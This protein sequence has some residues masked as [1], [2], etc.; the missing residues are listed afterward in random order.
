MAG[1]GTAGCRT[2]A[3]WAQR[4][5]AGLNRVDRPSRRLAPDVLRVPA[6]ERDRGVDAAA[7][8]YQQPARGGVHGRDRGVFPAGRESPNQGTPSDAL[9][10]GARVRH[11]DRA[12]HAEHRGPGLQGAGQR[13]DMVPGPPADRTGQGPC[14][15]R[16]GGGGQ[17]RPG[18]GGDGPHPVCSRQARVSAARRPRRCP[19]HVPEPLGHVLPARPALP[20]SDQGPHRRDR[21]VRRGSD[22]GQTGVRPQ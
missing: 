21:G 7:D 11:R 8:R 5:A 18:S 19:D 16:P 6:A 22:R 2:P 14:A 1:G 4:E 20:R 17:R 3:V 15:R 13:R 9:E 10:A 12:G